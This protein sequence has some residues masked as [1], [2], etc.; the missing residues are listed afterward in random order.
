M[1]WISAV[2]AI[3]KGLPVIR[4][5]IEIFT[6]WVSGIKKW[7]QKRKYEKKQRRLD[8]AYTK[9]KKEKNT[10]DL[11]KEIEELL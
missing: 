7:W 8:E 4:D 2:I 6:G 5:L 10:E 11:Q 3:F 1:S 9:A